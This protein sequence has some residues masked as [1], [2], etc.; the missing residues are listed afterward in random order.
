M[1]PTES[2]HSRPEGK[3]AVSARAALLGHDIRNAVSDIIGGLALADLEPLDDASK[4]QLQRARSAGEQLA[5]LSDEV[6]ALVTGEAGPG[7]AQPRDLNF[8][9]FLK[10]V[11]ARWAAHAHS[12]GL[13][14]ILDLA[15]DLP[16]MIGTKQNALERILA[17]LIGNSMKHTKAGNV[18]LSVGIGARETL[19]LTVRDDGPGFSEAAQS[20]LFERGGRPPESETPGTGMG[21]HI[22]H[23]LVHQINGRMEVRNR[24]EGGAE[25]G[26]LLP[27][28]AWA[29]GV[30]VP[31]RADKLPDLSG[32]T[33][34]VAED[35][36]TNQLLIRQMLDTLGA[37]CLIAADGREALE[38]LNSNEF[39]LALIDIEM[40]RLSG[41]DLI[42]TLRSREEFGFAADTL[43]VL[44]ITAY[45]LSANRDEI[46][47]AGADGILA[48]PI[49]S[50]EAFGEAIS[51]ILD[52]SIGS[53][54]A[55]RPIEKP[56]TPAVSAVHLDR[57]LALAGD[58]DAQELLDRLRQDIGNV[59]AGV[60]EG[61]Q[62]TDFALLRGRTHVLISLA[63]AIGSA[64][65]QRVA[66][67]LNDAAH[68][69]DLMLIQPLAPRVLKLIDDVLLMLDTEYSDRF[70]AGVA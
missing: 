68:Q 48:K 37:Q 21:L 63:G 12:H 9:S 11:E 64:E 47:E 17:N 53:I 15:A 2:R 40:P 28:A 33:V 13:G 54:G 44:A 46:Y 14:F 8:V 62:R 6:L 66:E 23:D 30:S 3:S 65:L 25:V 38:L 43:P 1:T 27:R 26:I 41:L 5:R 58:K 70:N 39:D 18:T 42:R 20:L 56:N 67:T 10:D 45:V 32:W 49:M 36:A 24:P 16:P 55:V 29:P 61:L 31:G 59:R 19:H 69:K 7:D 60:H 50:L 51:A 57:L 52:K 4:Q 22:V 35:N 34:L